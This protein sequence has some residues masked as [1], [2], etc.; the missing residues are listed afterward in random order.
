MILPRGA[1][2]SVDHIDEAPPGLGES[3]PPE[4][5]QRQ[6]LQQRGRW[7]RRRERCLAGGREQSLGGLAAQAWH[8]SHG[9]F[10]ST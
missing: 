9:L 7:Y 4:P 3:P 6:I 5:H 8:P 10:S 1:A 2:E